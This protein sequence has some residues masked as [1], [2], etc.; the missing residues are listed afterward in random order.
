MKHFKIREQEY[1]MPTEWNDVTLE[2]YVRL[3]ELE[4]KKEAFGIPELYLLKVLECLCN[5]EDGDLD[6]LTLDI[7]NE[8]VGLIGYI[9]EEPNWVNTNHLI[10]D[11]VDYVFPNDLNR[12]TMGE[13]ISIKTLQ[14]NN[15]TAGIIPYIL[16]IILRPGTKEVDAETGKEKWVQ[17]K[18]STSNLEWRKELFMKQ[19]VFNLMG[20]VTFFLNGKEI[21]TTNTKDSIPEAQK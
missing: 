11:E 15:T 8:L 12:L 14:E 13:Y 16:A 17:E 2:V 20:P 7:V 18:F 9:Q 6:E 3:A 4:E 21:Y 19:P 1:Q 5:A 10:I